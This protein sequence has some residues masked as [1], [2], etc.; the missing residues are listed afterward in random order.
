M[1]QNAVSRG[2]CRNLIGTS[3]RNFESKFPTSRTKSQKS[4][5]TSGHPKV[6][7]LH[8]PLD[9]LKNSNRTSGHQKSKSATQHPDN[10][11]LKFETDLW[12]PPSSA[13]KKTVQKAWEFVVVS[14][15]TNKRLLNDHR[16]QTKTIKIH[17]KFSG[18]VIAL[19]A[20][21]IYRCFL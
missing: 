13:L 11:K 14:N 7:M 17:W 2:R 18:I 21:W 1:F 16:P 15:A 10:E 19:T 3:K 5:R 20:L 8:G 6:K 4:N 9:T 12:T